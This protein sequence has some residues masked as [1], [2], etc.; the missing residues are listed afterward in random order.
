[1]PLITVRR[2]Q[3]HGPGKGQKLTVQATMRL[4]CYLH[5]CYVACPSALLIFLAHM[6][7]S[8]CRHVPT[9]ASCTTFRTLR[10][11]LMTLITLLSSSGW[12]MCSLTFAFI[13]LP[14]NAQPENK[15]LC[16]RPSCL[17]L[18]F[19]VVQCVCS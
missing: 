5:A 13:L 1:M 18:F 11:F 7:L 17:S 2:S 9:V 14:Q 8:A 15:P 6:G 12:F 10:A 3:S 16:I 19:G 4:A